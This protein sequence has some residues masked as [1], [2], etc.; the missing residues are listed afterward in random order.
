MLYAH[1]PEKASLRTFPVFF[2]C[3]ILYS[4]LALAGFAGIFHIRWLFMNHAAKVRKN[5][6]TV[7]PPDLTLSSFYM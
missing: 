1:T 4:R 7:N 3:K 6:Q 5:P 2:E